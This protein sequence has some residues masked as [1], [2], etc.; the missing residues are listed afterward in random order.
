[1][2]TSKIYTLMK[3]AESKEERAVITMEVVAVAAAAQ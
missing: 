3:H 1:M 2:L